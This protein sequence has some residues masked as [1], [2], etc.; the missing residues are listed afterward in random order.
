MAICER[1]DR[2]A[3]SQLRHGRDLVQG[4]TSLSRAYDR[5][6]SDPVSITQSFFMLDALAWT[7]FYLDSRREMM[8]IGLAAVSA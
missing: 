6:R 1:N 7:P 5:E 3:M 2:P 8:Q 4:L